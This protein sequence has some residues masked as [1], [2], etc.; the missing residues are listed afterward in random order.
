[1]TNQTELRRLR[2]AADAAWELER[3]ADA[4]HGSHDSMCK[5]VPQ[6]PVLITLIFT[7]K[8]PGVGSAISMSS[9]PAIGLAL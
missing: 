3:A 8:G 9:N 6:I 4:A 5:S 1:M 2:D 7:S